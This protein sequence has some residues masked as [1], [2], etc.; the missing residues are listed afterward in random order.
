MFALGADHLTF[1]GMELCFTPNQNKIQVKNKSDFSGFFFNEK[2]LYFI[3]NVPNIYCW[4]LEN[5]CVIA[6]FMS[7]HLLTH[8]PPSTIHNPP[9]Q[10]KQL[11]CTGIGELGY[12]N[13]ILNFII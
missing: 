8:F 11:V 9:T 5:C 7:G 2:S 4:K 12:A 1:R 10:L 3:Q 13:T 6:Y